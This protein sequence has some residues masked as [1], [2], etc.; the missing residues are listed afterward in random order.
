MSAPSPLSFLG[1]SPVAA[2]AIA[3]N[4][5][6]AAASTLVASCARGLFD[7]IPRRGASRRWFGFR[8]RGC[9]CGRT[10]ASW[11]AEPGPTR[12]RSCHNAIAQRGGAAGCGAGC[13]DAIHAQ[14][15]AKFGLEL[16]AR[17]PKLSGPH[18]EEAIHMFYRM[19]QMKGQ[20]SVPSETRF[21]LFPPVYSFPFA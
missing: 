5:T 16:N 19:L 3:V 17:L 13:R 18:C 15:V 7:G 10:W 14:F 1:Q 9:S 2:A 12:T 11:H 8:R 20:S 4:Q 6:R 21:V